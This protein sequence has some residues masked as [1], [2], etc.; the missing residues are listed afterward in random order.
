M[1]NQKGF[2]LIEVL[3]VLSIKLLIIFLIVPLAYENLTKTKMDVFFA[4][5]KSDIDLV[6]S[7]NYQKNNFYELS[8]TKGSYKLTKNLSNDI[9][10]IKEK[11]Y[12]ED[13]TIESRIFKSVIYQNNGTFKT[14][15][16]II[17][18]EGKGKK[19]SHTLI[20]PFGKG[21]FYIVPS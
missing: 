16:H 14:P 8:F 20:F 3:V 10:L 5:L 15:G 17:F 9:I 11:S 18:K 19:K 21:G 1:I 4:E 6:Q 7:H 2:T 12:P 13:V